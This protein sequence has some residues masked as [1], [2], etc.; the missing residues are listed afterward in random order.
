MRKNDARKLDH[1]TLEAIRIR[2]VQQVKNGESPE[3]VISALGMDRTCIYKWLALYHEGGLEA[4]KAKPLSGRP[5]LLAPNQIRWIYQTIV[6]KNPLQ[7]KFEFAL[8]T[9]QMVLVLIRE[10]FG[11]ELS[12]VSVGRLLAKLGLTP[13]RPLFRAYQQEGPLVSKWLET[14]FPRLQLRAKREGAEIYF[15]DE[16]GIR[17]D[18]HNGTTW[19]P[20]GETPVVKVT[21]QRFSLNMLSAISARGEMRFM[22]VKGKVNGGVFIAFLKRLIQNSKRKIYLVVDGHPT[23]RA[24]QTREFVD[25]VSD[26]LELVFLP[27]YSPELNPDEL[28]WND[29]KG[30]IGRSRIAGRWDLHRTVVRHLRKIQKNP[31]HVRSYFREKHVQYAM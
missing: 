27:A 3:S 30:K 12:L 25:S 18:H 9:R 6:T 23:H 11:I 21:G 26:R 16:A 17:S 5:T 24:K 31:A 7:M 19:A 22:V 2:A 14:D 8:W 20:K 1:K 29:V 15:A 28:V 10:R 13:Q 4:L